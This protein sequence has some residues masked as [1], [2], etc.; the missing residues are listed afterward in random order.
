MQAARQLITIIS[1]L[2]MRLV[3]DGSAI[4]WLIM[5]PLL[6]I[7]VLGVTVQGLFSPNFIPARPFRVAITEASSD[8]QQHL[9][10]ALGSQEDF[11]E[12]I[13]VSDLDARRMVLDRE[14]DAAV[15]VPNGYPEEAPVVVSEPGQAVG[16]IL[17]EFIQTERW[18]IAAVDS[19]VE[20]A[21]MEVASEG[22]N[23][24]AGDSPWLG[25][26]AFEYY[27]VGLTV[28]FV[29]FAAHHAMVF[30]A[31]DRESGA[32]ARVRAFG[33]K[34]ETYLLGGWAAA[35]A[36]GVAF[37]AVMAGLTRLLFGVAW[38]DWLGWLVLTAVTAAA[39]ASVSFLM[40]SVV[41]KSS[42]LEQLGSTVFMI[43]AMASGS[44]IPL[45]VLPSWLKSALAWLPSRVALE[46]YFQLS[47]G[48]HLR[49]LAPELAALGTTSLILFT[50]GWLISSVRARGEA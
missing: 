1:G 38:G 49:N 15:L 50:L 37:I 23:T 48:A 24:D 25:L 6:I 10:R 4:V 34:R 29:M 12:I 18:S 19:A 43:M 47:D 2:L 11:F 21:R 9:I 20:L 39:M 26:S 17:E 16:S 36:I 22:P 7:F 14:V 30:T 8:A 3:R 41:A 28:M 33:V 35:V 5:L 27:A 13:P 45:H 31:G 44:S 40:S 42:T 32:Y 46:G